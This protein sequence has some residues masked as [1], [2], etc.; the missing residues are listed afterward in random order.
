V[1]VLNPLPPQLPAAHIALLEQV[2][3]ATV[4]HFLHSSFVDPTIRAVLPE[5]RVAGTAVTLRIPGADS[6]LLHHVLGLVRPGDFL[7]IDRAGDTRHAC[8]GGVVTNA[9]KVAGVVGAVIDGPATDFS[10]IRRCDMPMWCRGPSPITTKLLGLEGAFN[11]PVTVGGQTVSPGDAILADE[12]GVLVLKPADV[13]AVARRAL[14]M[15]EREITTLK[16]IHAGEKL[17]D[18]S[19]ATRLIEETNKRAAAR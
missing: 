4:G 3:T 9:A 14:G 19:G 18:I 6:T 12:S 5:K 17:A 16:R 1:F 7:V 8:W 11:V 10:E 15:Q 13:E 2:E